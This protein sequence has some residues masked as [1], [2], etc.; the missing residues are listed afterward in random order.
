MDRKYLL[1]IIKKNFPILS[2][3][4]IS[5]KIKNHHNFN[6][7][8]KRLIQQQNTELNNEENQN[9]LNDW[10]SESVYY[11]ADKV[12]K[13]KNSQDEKYIIDEIEELAEISLIIISAYYQYSAICHTQ[14]MYGFVHLVLTE[15][16]LLV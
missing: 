4:E 12:I 13:L 14:L 7:T 11:I 3:N 16:I 15:K 8:L 1:K 9:I 6:D 5:Q 2:M 10:L